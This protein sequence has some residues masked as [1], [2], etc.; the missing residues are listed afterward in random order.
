[1]QSAGM[2]DL[3]RDLG[4]AKNNM[5]SR[6]SES[7]SPL[8]TWNDQLQLAADQFFWTLNK[9]QQHLFV[10]FHPFC[11]AVVAIS[12]LPKNWESLVLRR[13]KDESKSC[14]RET[15]W[16]MESVAPM[17]DA[18]S[19]KTRMLRTRD[20]DRRWNHCWGS[21]Q[22]GN[23]PIH[24][25]STG[26]LQDWYL[27]PNCEPNPVGTWVCRCECKPK[28]VNDHGFQSG[29]PTQIPLKINRIWAS[30]S[31]H[32]SGY[33]NNMD[34][35]LHLYAP[36]YCILTSCKLSILKIVVHLSAL[37]WTLGK[38]LISETNFEMS[39]DYRCGL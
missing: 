1:M 30:L 31:P 25:N 26:N 19:L 39:M 9:Q 24:C 11:R 16:F 7:T 37:R 28:L 20:S 4:L 15:S 12:I 35:N 27:W 18:N 2:C 38:N 14:C 33:P 29:N 17:A 21:I 22:W 10:G 36:T 8:L 6:E 5:S 13:P 32:I 23:D 3:Q 34:T